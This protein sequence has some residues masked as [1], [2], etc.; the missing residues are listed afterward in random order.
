MSFH[1]SHP[2]QSQCFP[3]RHKKPNIPKQKFKIPTD[4]IEFWKTFVLFNLVSDPLSLGAP[5]PGHRVS[6]VQHWVQNLPRLPP[7][8]QHTKKHVK[9]TG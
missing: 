5:P 2:K 3:K 4:Q 1:L 7:E 9:A 8:I 6:A